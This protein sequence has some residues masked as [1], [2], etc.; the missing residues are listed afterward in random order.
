MDEQPIVPGGAQ[1]ASWLKQGVWRSAR[2]VAERARE[3]GAITSIATQKQRLRDNGLPFVV[4]IV[5]N[6]A[7]KTQAASAATSAN[8]NP[9]LPYDPELFVG[10]A[11]TQRVVLLNKYNVVDQHLLIVTREFQSQESCLTLSDFAALTDVMVAAETEPLAFYNSGQVAGASQAHKHLQVVPLFEDASN[12]TAPL[13]PIIASCVAQQH[14]GEVPLLSFSHTAARVDPARPA[15]L[16]ER[17]HTLYLELLGRQKLVASGDSSSAPAG[18]YNLL[19][20]RR[21]MLLV[22]RVR[23]SFHGI[24]LNALAFGG[25]LLVKDKDQWDVLRREG[26]LAALRHVVR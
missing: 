16:P 19:L 12:L 22:P 17:L 21:W 11:G 20:T 5:E 13:D 4:R 10:E 15:D 18:P 6:L 9:F 14:I 25:A 8:L 26:P 1:P 2:I 3:R 24:S 23:E 7:H